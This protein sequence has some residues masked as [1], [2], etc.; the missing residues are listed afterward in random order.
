MHAMIAMDIMDTYHLNGFQ[1]DST[2]SSFFGG[3]EF[4]LSHP[5]GI[6]FDPH[7]PGILQL[8]SLSL[9]MINGLAWIIKHG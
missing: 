3:E 7:L 9:A 8:A 4:P 2:L 1:S 5:T 6:V